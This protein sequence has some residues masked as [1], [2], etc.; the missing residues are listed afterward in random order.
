MAQASPAAE[1]AGGLEE[2]VVTTNRCQDN[3]PSV[4]IAASVITPEQVSALGI[5]DI[6]TLGENIPGAV[7]QRQSN[8]SLPF[9]C[10]V[11]N[12]NS[13]AGAQSGRRFRGL[14]FEP[15]RLARQT[16]G[17][18]SQQRRVQRLQLRNR[19]RDAA[20]GGGAQP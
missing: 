17:P 18:E 12:P 20:V 5:T 3:N 14:G 10:G 16:V 1:S 8:G 2:V 13:T 6:D 11:G 9:L 7:F 19:H 4:P 15:G